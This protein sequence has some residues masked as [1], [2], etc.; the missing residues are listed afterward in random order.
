MNNSFYRYLISLTFISSLFFSVANS[1]AKAIDLY[2]QSKEGKPI[3]TVDSDAGIISIFT[4][5]DNTT[6]IKVADP[7]N[8]N[9]GWV[10]TADLANATIHMNLIN[11]G[12]HGQSYQMIQF[13]QPSAQVTHLMQQQ[14]YEMQRMMQDF[15]NDTQQN[16]IGFPHWINSPTMMP[17]F[18]LPVKEVPSDSSQSNSTTKK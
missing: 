16:W 9:V 7:R 18:I 11:T 1:Y 4:P 10:K 17:V 14:S 6:W 15:F 8:G 3:G 5:K 12:N 13:G 2:D